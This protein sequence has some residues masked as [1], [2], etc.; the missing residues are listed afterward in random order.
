METNVH[1]PAGAMGWLASIE[2]AFLCLPARCYSLRALVRSKKYSAARSVVNRSAAQRFPATG[3][4][5]APAPPA[6]LNA[7]ANRAA[8]H[9]G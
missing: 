6:F 5:P 3:G 8:R 1:R 9:G 7:T 2:I 4:P